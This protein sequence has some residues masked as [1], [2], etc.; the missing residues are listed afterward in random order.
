MSLSRYDIVVVGGGA[1]GFTAAQTAKTV[2][3]DKSVLL[4][5]KEA[6]AVIPCAIPYVAFTIDSCDKM[7]M[8]YDVLRKLGVD[9]VVD[10][11]VDVDRKGKRVVTASGKSFE[12]GKLILAVGGA[13]SAPP[14]EGLN[15][16][17]V[18]MVYKGYE[19]VAELQKALREVK[20]VVI[21]GGG[22]IGVE[23]ADDLSELK[24]DVTI[25]E[26]LPHCLLLNF[27][28]EFAAVAEE[29]LR[30]KG[31]RIVT[32]RTVKRVL[33]KEA[34][35]GVELDNGERIPADLVIVATGY[36][37]STELAKKIGLR[38][39]EYGIV[40]DDYMRTSDPDILAVGD[41][42]E[43]KHFLLGT[44]TPALLASIAC[45][46]AR[47]AILNLYGVRMSRRTEG[48]VGAFVTKI[49]N[50]VLGASGATERFAKQRNIEY[51][52]GKAK[53]INRHPAWL[54]GGCEVEVKLVFLKS[55]TLI[56]AQVAGYCNEVAELAN[57]LALAVQ[58]KMR[59]DEIIA[60]QFGTHPKLTA[61]PI[62]TP[63]ILAALDAYTKL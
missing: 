41:C 9:I 58:N 46:E 47:I 61:S 60:M 10:E 34:A 48:W 35:E 44:P 49:G 13:P 16:K 54:P 15:L 24:K 40:V 52:A 39:S 50:L 32:G 63:V 38:V 12:Y 43:K 5:T 62:S 27:D 19:K 22:F 55:G 26:I 21:I 1:G 45:Q 17:N 28:E 2:Y 18:Y 25:V 7:L 23:L 4:I 53:A 56:G 42:A 20:R 59:I 8:P 29:E 14:I 6:K 11:V 31:V 36:R 57:A 30:K 3:K 51:V 33:G 37:P